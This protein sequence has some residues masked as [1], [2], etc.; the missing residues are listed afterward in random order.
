[1][2]HSFLIY[3]YA[4][5]HL[6]CFRVLAIENSAV[7][8]IG[9]HV[10]IS[11]LVSSVC[12]PSIGISGSHGSSIFNFLRTL[13]TILHSG[14]IFCIPIYSVRGFPF[15]CILSSIYWKNLH[16]IFWPR[17]SGGKESVCSEGDLFSILGSGRSPGKR[18]GYHF[19]ILAWI[20][21]WTEE[22]GRL[23]SMGSQRIRHNW[24]TNNTLKLANNPSACI[25]LANTNPSQFS[26]VAQ[27]CLPNP[28]PLSR[29]CHPTISSSAVPFSSHLQSFPASGSFQMSQ[30][31]A[32]GGQSIGT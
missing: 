4:D 6:G 8:N 15:L 25:S 24:M 5:G 19:S 7:M 27:S 18:K 30:L 20:I 14:Y 28:C 13:L 1:M 3:S 23:Q 11:I 32:S 10:C 16:C 21:P 2:Y 29:W 9:V 17:G 26:S 22:S 31:F 12:V